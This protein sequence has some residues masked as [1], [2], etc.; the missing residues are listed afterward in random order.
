MSLR[1]ERGYFLCTMPRSGSTLLCDLL[2][3]TGTAGRPNSFF[4]PQSMA[5]F[6]ACW[7][8]PAQTLKVFDQSYINTVLDRGTAGT[9]CFGMR[10]MWNN[11]PD[12]ITRLGQLFPQAETDQERLQA[13]FG[14]LQFIHLFRRDK[15]AEAVSYAIAEQSGLW[16]RNAD[17]TELER[18]S[19]PAEPVYDAVHIHK[20]YQIVT[21]GSDAW[22]RWFDAQQITPF[23]QAYEDLADNP[24]GHLR[25]I[26]QFLNIDPSKS[27]GI[28]PGTAR[29]ADDR[30]AAW[31]ARFRAEA[32]IAPAPT[33]V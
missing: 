33:Q 27:D 16:H 31:A 8:V 15:V 3:Q 7:G 5:D 19:P 10:I 22:Q 4:R 2:G 11:V 20:T 30:N 13:A 28:T 32:G 18:I 9:G 23:A 29:L 26:L 14:P 1:P 24:T 25:K 21:E 17:G 12:L 6:A